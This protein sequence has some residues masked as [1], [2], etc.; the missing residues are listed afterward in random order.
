[1]LFDAVWLGRAEDG[2]LISRHFRELPDPKKYADYYK[3]IAQP[4]CLNELRERLEAAE[5]A[6]RA[7]DDDSLDGAA[8][9]GS[10]ARK[11]KREKRAPDRSEEGDGGGPRFT[12]SD[13]QRDLRRIISNAKR[14]NLPEAQA[15]QDALALEVRAPPRPGATQSR[16][17]GG[18]GRLR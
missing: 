12:L 16:P 13:L 14:Y 15:Y 17:R 10:S 6:R 2:S 11:R 18:R 8:V 9:D 7:R 5:A 4:V 3:I 1:M